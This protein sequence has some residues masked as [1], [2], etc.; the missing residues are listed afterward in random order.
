MLCPS[1]VLSDRSIFPELSFAY[2]VPEN[3]INEN[4]MLAWFSLEFSDNGQSL[5]GKIFHLNFNLGLVDFYI[6]IG[7][8]AC[9]TGAY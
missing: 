2:I 5:P 3:K 8:P 4:S 7:R 1:W 6:S 9:Y